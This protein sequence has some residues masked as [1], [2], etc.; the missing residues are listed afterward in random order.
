M[1]IRQY[2]LQHKK[3][4]AMGIIGLVA[5]LTAGMLIRTRSGDAK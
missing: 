2:Y 5:L 3:L 4:T 1:N